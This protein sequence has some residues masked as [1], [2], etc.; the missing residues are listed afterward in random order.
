MNIHRLIEQHR[1]C[2]F[3]ISP[4]L[5]KTFIFKCVHHVEALIGPLAANFFPKSPDVTT[6][7]NIVNVFSFIVL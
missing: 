2:E 5:L 4:V 6:I 7:P 3:E 1:F